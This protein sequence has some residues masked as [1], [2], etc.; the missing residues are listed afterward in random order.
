M[1]QDS[2]AP[3]LLDK[4]FARFQAKRGEPKSK[5]PEWIVDP[6]DPSKNVKN[7]KFV[8]EDDLGPAPQSITDL[9]AG[10]YEAPKEESKRQAPQ[11]NLTPDAISKAAGKMDF[12][13]NLPPELAEKV[14]SSNGS[15]DF[16]T[17]SALINHAGRTAYSRAMEHGT[18]L[19]GNFVE[20]RV[21]HERQGLPEHLRTYLAKSRT[22]GKK[23]I[24]NPVVREHMALISERIAN[25]FPDATE[26][27][28]AELTHEY[29]TTMAREINPDAFGGPMDDKKGTQPVG[30]IQDFDSYLAGTKTL[31]EA[32]QPVTA[33]TPASKP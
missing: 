7:P 33:K 4:I 28:I 12:M 9:Y 23:Q 19:T 32:R 16:E 14:K 13:A 27:E 21:Q 17:L 29:F 10:L 5:E 2:S 30:E 22:L 11:F 6:N 1:A 25:K 3:S 26:D 31:E 18:A 20:A 24:D 15:F 8:K